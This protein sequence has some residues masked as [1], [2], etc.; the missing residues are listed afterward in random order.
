MEN[1]KSGKRQ[2]G[3][4]TALTKRVMRNPEPQVF[5]MCSQLSC[6]PNYKK[7]NE[8]CIYHCLWGL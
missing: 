4:T 5:E 8:V 7:K 1:R 6:I 3:E 2:T